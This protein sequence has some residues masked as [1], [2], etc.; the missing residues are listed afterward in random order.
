MA[1]VIPA[2][3]GRMGSNEYFLAKM[4]A[5]ELVSTIRPA[6]EMDEWASMSIEERLQ[7][8]LAVKRVEQEIVPYL[9]KSPDRLWGSLI[10]LI[11]EGKVTFEELT[12]LGAKLP[13]AYKSVSESIGFLTVDGGQL[14]ALDGQH[15]LVALRDVIQGKAEGDYVTAVPNDDISVVF[16]KHESHQKT[17]RI[18]NKVNRHAKPTGRGD[19]IIT[20]EDDGYAIVTRRLLDH[21]APLGI[22]V[23]GNDLIVNWKSNTLSDRSVQ[24]TTISAVYETV[25]DILDHEGIKQF[26]EKHLVNRPSEDELDFAYD[27]VANWWSAVLG[28][29]PAFAAALKNPTNIPNMRKAS[30]ECSLLFKPVGQIALFKGLIRAEH[31][32]VALTTAVKRVNDIDWRIEADLWRGVLVTP[33]GKMMTGKDEINL[34]GALIGFLLAPDK[35]SEAEID[36]LK[37]RYNEARATV[38]EPLPL[39]TA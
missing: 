9:A 35:H 23:K 38:N 3:R 33:D 10:V 14:I 1:V 36:A 8:D 31:K 22:K 5:R 32:K 15:R 12:S 7:R 13:A 21:D 17:R 4:P 24:F 37:A 39:V 16:V 6:K 34:A 20:S 30:A 25:R 2:I 18:F 19:N 28:G 11:Y 29:V 27:R 26:D